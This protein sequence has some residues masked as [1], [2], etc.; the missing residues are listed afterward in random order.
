MTTAP[1]TMPF[2]DVTMLAPWVVTVMNPLRT[3]VRRP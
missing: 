2:L 1:A 3:G